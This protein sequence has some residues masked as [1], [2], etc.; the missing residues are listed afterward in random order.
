M[1]CD[2]PTSP[3]PETPGTLSAQ[4]TALVNTLFGSSTITVVGDRPVFQACFSET[5]LTD[6]GGVLCALK[7]AFDAATGATT[8]SVQMVQ[9]SC[10]PVELKPPAQAVEVFATVAGAPWSPDPYPVGSASFLFVD[11][12]GNLIT[13]VAATLGLFVG[14]DV[15]AGFS[16]PPGTVIADIPDPAVVVVSQPSQTT[17][18]P[19]GENNQITF[20]SLVPSTCSLGSWICWVSNKLVGLETWKTETYSALQGFVLQQVGSATE[21]R[22]SAITTL[23][24]GQT[25]L[26]ASNALLQSQ[27]AG[28]QTAYNALLARVVSLETLTAAQ[29]TTLSGKADASAVMSLASQVSALS[30]D[31]AAKLGTPVYYKSPLVY[32]TSGSAGVGASKLVA[33]SA[34][35]TLDARRNYNDLATGIPSGPGTSIP[36]YILLGVTTLAA[37][38]DV[39]VSF[40]KA[41]DPDADLFNP[42]VTYGFGSHS[43]STKVTI[44]VLVPVTCAGE[45]DPATFKYK[46]A[47]GASAH[48]ETEISLLAA[49]F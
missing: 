15:A 2:C 5:E 44:P 39:K 40:S 16:F 24:V 17:L 26:A 13:D 21:S 18:G 27:V 49:F 9:Y 43:A 47:P 42:V 48:Y 28:L 4:L 23:Q 45:S 32:W 29:G 38:G 33:N 6:A 11:A 3:E 41:S 22:G 1:S 37:Q 20:S 19:S 8:D 31:V 34:W 36:K 35:H 7:A 12:E 30:T 14:M 25:A 46:I 10:L